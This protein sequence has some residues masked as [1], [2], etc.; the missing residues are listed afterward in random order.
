[1]LPSRICSHCHCRNTRSLLKAGQLAGQTYTVEVSLIICVRPLLGP[2]NPVRLVR[3][4]A[5]SSAAF[6]LIQ[7]MMASRFFRDVAFYARN[8]S[9]YQPIHTGAWHV[10]VKRGFN[11]RPNF[12]KP[13]PVWISR[14]NAPMIGVFKGLK[15]CPRG[16]KHSPH[17]TFSGRRALQ[18]ISPKRS[19]GTRATQSHAFSL[20]ISLTGASPT[21]DASRRGNRGI[22][23]AQA[24][25]GW[26]E[27]SPAPPSVK[28]RYQ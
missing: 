22:T 26:L 20:L 16:R 27:R 9:E 11:R 17:A 25:G 15:S 24:G 6:A 3:S 14:S 7:A 28:V 12:P 19:S 1:V 4:W 13:T 5:G 2:F 23:P 10:T 21:V 8:N 18:R